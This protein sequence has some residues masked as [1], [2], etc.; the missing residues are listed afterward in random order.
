[1]CEAACQ[2]SWQ[3]TGTHTRWEGGIGKHIFVCN[4][5]RERLDSWTAS[6]HS[7]AGVTLSLCRVMDRQRLW[8]LRGVA[9]RAVAVYVL[10]SGVVR[11]LAVLAA[12]LVGCIRRVVL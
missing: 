3:G 10:S 11:G 9:G 7:Q 2:R 12:P 8:P 1:M 6:A 5:A 4:V